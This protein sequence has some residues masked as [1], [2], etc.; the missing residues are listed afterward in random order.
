MM[1]KIKRENLYLHMPVS[2]LI[3]DIESFLSYSFNGQIYIN[4]E[5]VDNYSL[6]DIYYIKE[7]FDKKKLK[8]TLHGP[9]VDL[10]CGSSDSKVRAVTKER[11]LKTVEIAQ[12]LK[13]ESITFHSHYEPIFY[14]KHF[15]HWIENSKTVWGDVL[16]KAGKLGVQVLIENSI[17][18]TP[19]A[20]LRLTNELVN[21]NACFDVAHYNAFY[22]EGWDNALDAYPG[23][24]IKEVHLSDND[25][26]SDLHREL[27][28]GNINFDMFF[29]KILDKV[30]D[31]NF[32]IE[33]HS[34]EDVEKS[35]DFM[36]KFM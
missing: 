22:Q 4:S 9:F 21:L 25:G 17:E 14:K 11:F 33:S 23:D 7:A 35:I 29:L 26:K 18:N 8:R 13:A 1:K 34:M 6:S 27:G 24:I 30:V 32:V 28:G 15:N 12:L 2:Y 16:E 20:V 19:A 36:R 5:F 3:K 31:A 10:N